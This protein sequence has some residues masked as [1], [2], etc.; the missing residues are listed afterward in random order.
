MSLLVSTLPDDL[1][2]CHA[3][4]VRLQE[5]LDAVNKQLETLQATSHDAAADIASLDAL[6]KEYQERNAD[7]QRTIDNL[8]ADNATLKRSLFGSRRERFVDDPSQQLMFGATTLETPIP[9]AVQEEP[10][11]GRAKRTSKGRKPRVFP[12]LLP[13]EEKRIPLSLEEIPEVMRDNPN[14]RRFFKKIGET[15]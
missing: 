7:L 12:D 11:K 13:R 5:Q 14:A 4:I 8:A 2:S 1:P 3:M 10:E 6:V 15:L 9:D